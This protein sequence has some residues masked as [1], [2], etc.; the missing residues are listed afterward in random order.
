MKR[1]VLL[2]RRPDADWR[3]LQSEFLDFKT[4]L[5]PWTASAASAWLRD[6]Y[7]ADAERDA[8]IDAFAVSVETT[9]SV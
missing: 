4:S 3:A 6:E 1:A 5:G 7:G 8:D 2:V 9:M